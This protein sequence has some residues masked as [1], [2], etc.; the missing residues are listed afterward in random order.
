MISAGSAPYLIKKRALAILNREAAFQL[1]KEERFT[2]QATAL[3]LSTLG[4]M[5]G[6]VQRREF[7]AEQ[8][9]V[10]RLLAQHGRLRSD[11][12]LCEF[13]SGAWGRELQETKNSLM[14]CH[15]FLDE[16]QRAYLQHRRENAKMHAWKSAQ[17]VRIAKLELITKKFEDVSEL[18][19][20]RLEQELR[21]KADEMETAL[22]FER[23]A[24]LR[25]QLMQAA[26][27]KVSR[28]GGSRPRRVEYST[29]TRPLSVVR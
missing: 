2:L 20:A 24:D 14:L 23:N 22:Q 18:D 26:Q 9:G 8:R 16:V 3:K 5:K 21:A 29:P 19:F 13:R 25:Q 15:K 27:D 12:A 6:A 10:Q 4:R 11:L 7:E 1:Q 28:G 17:L